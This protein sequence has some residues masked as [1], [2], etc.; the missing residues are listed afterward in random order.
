MA[1]I[2][3]SCRFARVFAGERRITCRLAMLQL[4]AVAHGD[5]VLVWRRR[6]VVDNPQHSTADYVT[7]IPIPRCYLI[8][9]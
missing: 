7:R 6:G 2:H 3:S 4:S 1:R 5:A 8:L 9:C